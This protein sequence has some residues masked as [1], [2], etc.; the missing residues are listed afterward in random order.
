MCPS[1]GG[2]AV[3]RKYARLWGISTAHFDPNHA[4]HRAG[5]ARRRPLEEILVRGSTFARGALKRRLYEAG[6]KQR[7]CELCG[8]TETWRGRRMA[9]ILDHI[10]GIRDDNRLDN[11]QI[12]CPNCAATLD[13]HCGRMGRRYPERRDCAHCGQSFRAKYAAHRFCSVRCGRRA[14]RTNRGVP[15]LA[16]RKV[17]RPTEKQ[18]RADVDALGFLATG[19]KYGVSDNAVRKWLVWYERER[20]RAAEGVARAEEVAV[21]KAA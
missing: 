1:G 12:V 14:P 3:L 16:S 20:E 19:R 21:R 4:R 11:L 2:H 17:A 9:L 10:N 13:T 7:C 18:L 5:R 15:N 8:Q 6:L